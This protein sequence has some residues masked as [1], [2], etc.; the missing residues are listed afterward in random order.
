MQQITVYAT[1]NYSVTGTAVNGCRSYDTLRIINTWPNPVVKLD[2]NPNL[3]NGTARTLQAGNY[4]AYLWQNGSTASSFLVNSLGTYY[5]TVTDGHSC[6]GTD[7]VH[8]TKMLPAPANFLFAD[9]AICSYGEV[10]LISKQLYNAYL[11]GNGEASPSVTITRPG[12]YWLQVTD[13]NNCKGVD[14]VKVLQK[15]CMRGLYIPTAFT[16]N[17]D[18]KN[19]IF[20][21]L[22]FGDVIKFN[23]VIYDRYGEVIFVSNDLNKGW[24]GTIRGVLQNTGTFT[25]VCRYHLAGEAQQIKS[26]SVILL[27]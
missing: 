16:P 23:W 1:G 21:A 24:D 13:N 5:V 17:H 15:D 6:H 3:C 8:I 4:I 25:W 20:R 10:V 2:P 14:S 9:T 11:W 27:H 26:G 19:D 7:S 12:L 22:L 18:S